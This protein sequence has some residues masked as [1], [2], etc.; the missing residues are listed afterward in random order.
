MK[1]KTKG[2]VMDAD[3][4]RERS[5]ELAAAIRKAADGAFQPMRSTASV[6]VHALGGQPASFVVAD[7]EGLE[8]QGHNTVRGEIAVF[9]SDHVA[10]VMFEGA[11]ASGRGPFRVD[12]DASSIQ[13][14]PRRALTTVTLKCQGI[15]RQYD[16]EFDFDRLPWGSELHAQY[17][18]R[19]APLVIRDGAANLHLHE[20]QRELLADLAAARA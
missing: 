5:A 3:E 1:I 10:F 16:D 19:D 6:I 12:D 20:V 9:T 11:A 13:V 14:L 2:T 7:R 17:V 4:V 15:G 8:Y 18:G